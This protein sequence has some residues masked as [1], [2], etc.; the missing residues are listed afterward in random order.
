MQAEFAV[1]PQFKAQFE[2]TPF[3]SEAARYRQM[4]ICLTHVLQNGIALDDP[5]LQP[6][7][8]NLPASLFDEL[9]TE[10]FQHIFADDMDTQSVITMR[11][12]SSSLRQAIENLNEYAALKRHAPNVLRSLLVTGTAQRRT[13]QELFAILCDHH[14]NGC[15]AFN[16]FYTY[17]PC[18]V[19]ARSARDASSE[20]QCHLH[21]HCDTTVSVSMSGRQA[22]SQW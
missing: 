21:V 3:A 7:S 22:R 1:R 8:N 15:G 4:T 2:S 12:M 13:L 14:C 9:P 5:T 16:L 11:G 17:R 18:N 6:T 20:S 19:P 10:M